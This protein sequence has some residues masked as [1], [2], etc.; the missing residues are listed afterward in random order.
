[1]FLDALAARSP[2][3]VGGPAWGA[4]APG[5][6]GDDAGAQGGRTCGLRDPL[7]GRAGARLCRGGVAAL[8]THLHRL[9]LHLS[10]ISHLHTHPARAG[11]LLESAGLVR[12]QGA[13]RVDRA[14]AASGLLVLLEERAESGI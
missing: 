8:G 7:S 3:A 14:G 13:R 2:I 11:A 4:D 9:L 12:F 6:S 5:G 10:E 1:H